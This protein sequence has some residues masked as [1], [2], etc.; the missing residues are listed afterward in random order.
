MTV[1]EF[2]RKAMQVF[3][4][5]TALL[6]SMLAATVAIA[7]DSEHSEIEQQLRL[8]ETPL[9]AELKEKGLAEVDAQT[10]SK[11]AVD[12][13]IRCWFSSLEY[14]AS[15]TKNIIVRLGGMTVVTPETPCV[16]EFLESAGVA[17]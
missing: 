17:K 7:G 8:L 2:I 11:Q 13:L 12:E 16:Y 14:S 4:R 10:A 15:G 9:K 6:L 1:A 3:T 5:S